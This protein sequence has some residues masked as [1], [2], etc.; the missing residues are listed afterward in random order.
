MK[1]NRPVTEDTDAKEEEIKTCE[2]K[3]YMLINHHG[4]FSVVWRAIDIVCCMAS[5][6]IYLW[7]TVFGVDEFHSFHEDFMYYS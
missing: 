7:F 2:M 4:I 3:N 6:Y 1:E 5:S